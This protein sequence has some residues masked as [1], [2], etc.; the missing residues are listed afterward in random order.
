MRVIAPMSTFSSRLFTTYVCAIG[1]I[2]CAPAEQPAKAP[3]TSFR[4]PAG[5][6][7]LGVRAFYV[8]DAARAYAAAPGQP[9]QIGVR[10]FYPA[11]SSDDAQ[12]HYADPALAAA[13]QE[14]D[15]NGVHDE[16]LAG[17]PDLLVAARVDAPASDAQRWP[18][19][20][21]GVGF[22]V[23]GI[24]YTVFAQ[25][26]A[27]RG[28]VVAVLDSP[29]LG[30][31]LGPDGAAWA[32]GEPDEALASAQTLE[33]TA[34]AQ[35]ATSWLLGQADLNI[36]SQRV[37]MM[38]HSL[39]G[40]AALEACRLDARLRACI[41]LDGHPFGP[42]QQAGLGGPSLVFMNQPVPR[43]TPLGP[44]GV[45]RAALWRGIAEHTDA[46]AYFVTI[47]E[48]SHLSFAD[49]YAVVPASLS[50]PLGDLTGDDL[51]AA[52]NDISYAFLNEAFAGNFTDAVPAQVAQRDF[53][54]LDQYG[55]CGGGS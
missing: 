45:E 1:L 54:R 49:F 39:G 46:C 44:L 5:T 35:A 17:W 34:D 20:L 47:S 12:A 23:S 6:M 28:F 32:A 25:D 16:T 37:A 40:A 11:A 4:Q 13:M 52:I 24:N 51:Y 33:L 55:A 22:G 30:F 7:P 2:T 19:V 10:L 48:I 15:Y 36:D 43:G 42:V 41:N 50:A 3:L 21:F 38:G 27:S 9:R 18:L 14:A 53:A 29:G 8:A 26:L 31:M